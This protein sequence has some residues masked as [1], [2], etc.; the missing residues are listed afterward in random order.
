MIH[1]EVG[2]DIAISLIGFLKQNLRLEKAVDV[3]LYEESALYIQSE[4]EAMDHIFDQSRYVFV[5]I[6]EDY[7]NDS[8]YFV[9]FKAQHALYQCIKD[10]DKRNRII[11]VWCSYRPGICVFGQLRG[12]EYYKRVMKNKDKNPDNFFLKGL[13]DLIE[14]GRQSI[15]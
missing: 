8:E 2:R 14:K 6:A 12:I 11:P 5:I 3:I 15:H 9:K 10:K 1:T 4:L 13:E 7:N